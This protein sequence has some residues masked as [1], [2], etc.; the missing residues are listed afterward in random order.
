MYLVVLLNGTACMKV[1]PVCHHPN[2][3]SENKP[4][5]ISVI[6]RDYQLLNLLLLKAHARQFLTNYEN[7]MWISN[8]HMQ[9]VDNHILVVSI[10][11][12]IS[13]QAMSSVPQIAKI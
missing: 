12:V 11:I 13:Y 3:I 4:F 10:H 2:E 5:D 8:F 6:T 7:A 1:L 9:I